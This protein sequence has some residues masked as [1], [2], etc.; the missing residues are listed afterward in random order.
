MKHPFRLS[1]VFTIIII[2]SGL[3]AQS[4]PQEI[5]PGIYKAAI[6]AELTIYGGSRYLYEHADAYERLIQYRA[7]KRL[8][9]DFALDETGIPEFPEDSPGFTS[10]SKDIYKNSGDQDETTIAISRNNKQVIV[11][12]AND[13][14]G[15]INNGM[16][17]YY[18]TNGGESWSTVRVPKVISPTPGISYITLGDPSIAS[19]DSG[20]FYYAYLTG[21]SDGSNLDNLVI[22]SSKDGK[23]WINGGLVIPEADMSGF[24]DKENI[25]VDNSHSSPHYG[26]IYL[27][28]VHFNDLTGQEGGA[29]MISWSDDRGKTWSSPVNVVDAIVKFSEIRTGKNGEVFL[30]F[31]IEDSQESGQHYFFVSTD[32]GSSFTQNIISDYILYPKNQN[33]RPSLKGYQGFRVYPYIA[34]DIDLAS[35]R[36]HLVYGSWIDKGI[37]AQEAGLF[38]VSSIDLGKTWTKPLTLGMSNPAFNSPGFDRFCPWVSVDQKTGITQCFYYSSERD[39][40][41]LLISA[42]R[43]KLTPD[44]KDFPT[45][46]EAADFDPTLVTKSNNIPF[47]G[48]YTGSDSWDSVYAS[49]WTEVRSSISTDGDVFVFIEKPY[50]PAGNTGVPMVIRSANLWLAAPSPNPS[51]SATIRVSYYLPRDAASEIALYSSTGVKIKTLA[52]EKT[53]SGTYTTAYS[54]AGIPSGTYILRLSTQYGS[55]ERNL[56][57]TN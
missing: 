51:R 8:G 14:P 41:N 56:V 10:I 39:P 29:G 52:E 24:E 17:A 12:G 5:T 28:W 48:D 49:A 26:R 44:L 7:L 34:H 47:I 22:A 6:E 19:G 16:P 50:S 57:I 54:L 13:L 38:Y 32:G 18:S 3:R 11:A 36:I 43:T 53:G 31:S 33:Y 46:L 45:S 55:V 42:Y 23:K 30:S 21:P 4:M 2:S 15:M 20:Y 25:W 35:N 27:S 37:G 9:C 1:L 40:D